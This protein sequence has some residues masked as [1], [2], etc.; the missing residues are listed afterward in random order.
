MEIQKTDTQ[1][2]SYTLQGFQEA[3]KWA[4]VFSKSQLIPKSFQGKVADC[5]I[6]VQ[7]ASELGV[8]PMQFLQNAYV[9]NGKPSIQSSFAIALANQSGILSGGIN[10]TMEGDGDQKKCTAWAKLK[11]TGERIESTV[12]IDEAKKEGWY[13]KQGSKWQSLPDLMLRYR[14]AMFLIRTHLPQVILGFQSKEELIDV[15][16]EKKT[17]NVTPIKEEKEM[18]KKI[19]SI[20]PQEKQEKEESKDKEEGKELTGPEKAKFIIDYLKE[21][22]EENLDLEAMQGF[23]QKPIEDFGEEEALELKSISLKCANENIKINDFFREGVD[24]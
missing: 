11:E 10:Y 22:L 18:P 15:H 23:F 1:K 3:Y 6:A 17:V 19:G 5:M 20:I 7:Y 8:S 4:E 24:G 13:T 14:S 16:G 21:K 12:S 9:I 2:T